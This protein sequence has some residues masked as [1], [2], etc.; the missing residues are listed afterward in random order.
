MQ[1]MNRRTQAERRAETQRALLGA[2][3]RLFAEKGYA[4]T[5]TPEIVAAAGVTRGA[6]YHHYADKTALFAAVVEEEHALL[7][8]AIN[9][10]AEGEDEPGPVRAL[11]AGGDAFLDAMQDEGRRRILLVDAPAVL[12]RAALDGIDARHGLR[13]L[14]EGV[15]AAIAAKAIRDLPVL[16]L[17]HLL[18]ALFDRAA[19]ARPEELADYRKAIKALIRGLKT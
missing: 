18:N 10:A 9:A 5:G 13:T 6:L 2:A 17:A 12:G 3:R 8:L 19:L 1:E 15:E 7:A 14:I 11:I 4:G 16:P